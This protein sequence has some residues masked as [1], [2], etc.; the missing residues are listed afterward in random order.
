MRMLEHRG[1]LCGQAPSAQVPDSVAVNTTHSSH[2]TIGRGSVW[3]GR[4]TA[5]WRR[6]VRCAVRASSQ[7]EVLHGLEDAERHHAGDRRGGSA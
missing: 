7:D 3:P 2:A 5:L 1:L 6:G 4:S